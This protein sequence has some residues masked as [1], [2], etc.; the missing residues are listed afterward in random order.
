MTLRGHPPA[1]SV[2]QA[3]NPPVECGKP[4]PALVIVDAVPSGAGRLVLMAARRA[5]LCHAD[6]H[7]GE[8]L[9]CHLLGLGLGGLSGLEQFSVAPLDH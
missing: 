1:V 2:C 7:A 9:A 5:A 6:K 4:I 3:D 8:L